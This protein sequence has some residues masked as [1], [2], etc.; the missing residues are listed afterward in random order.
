MQIT[1]LGQ[2]EKGEKMTSSESRLEKLKRMQADALYRH[3]LATD[4]FTR[5]QL[6]LSRAAEDVNVLGGIIREHSAKCE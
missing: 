4:N 2:G 6:R 5:A 1:V 3:K